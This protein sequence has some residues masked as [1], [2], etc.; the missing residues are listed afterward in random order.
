[1][2]KYEALGHYTETLE[3]LEKAKKEREMIVDG[4]YQTASSLQRDLNNERHAKMPFQPENALARLNINA[5][6]LEQV[7]QHILE[8]T[9]T[10]N[11]YADFCD[12]P[13]I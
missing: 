3:A 12:R 13:K 2:N 4:L 9:Q 1:M 7:Q 8:L 10:L 6:K 11:H 5:E